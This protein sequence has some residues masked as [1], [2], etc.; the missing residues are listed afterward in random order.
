MR[1]QK[2]LFLL[3]LPLLAQFLAACCDCL[4]TTVKNLTHC[5]FSISPIDNSGAAPVVAQSTAVPREAF[6]IRLTILLKENICE[7]A[8]AKNLFINS[9]YAA[10]CNCD[11]DMQ[12]TIKSDIEEIRIYALKDFATGK[13]A[14]TDITEH[15]YVYMP[16]DLKNEFTPLTFF[17]EGKQPMFPSL[18]NLT[19]EL[20]M[21]LMTPPTAGSEQQF[22]VEVL[23][24]DGRVFESET[25]VLELVP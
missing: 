5:S 17:L 18:N 11:D 6:G 16:D 1:L 14:N 24:S 3:L 13:P 15:F 19:V 10:S 9:A 23:L 22:K 25:S 2:V 8:P 7:A 21:L 12:H 4:S 20:D